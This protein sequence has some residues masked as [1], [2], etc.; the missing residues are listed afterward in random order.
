MLLDLVKGE[1]HVATL[2]P[3][4]MQSILDHSESKQALA[5]AH[6]YPAGG[7][8]QLPLPVRV[9]WFAFV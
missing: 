5:F 4:L 1:Q 8:V 2:K 3:A 9:I 7:A 6:W